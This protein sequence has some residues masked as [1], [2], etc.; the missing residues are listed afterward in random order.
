ME[1]PRIGI[2]GASGFVGRYLID[3]L[4]HQSYS[5]VA[6]SREKNPNLPQ[7]VKIINGDLGTGRGLASFLKN[8]DILVHLAGQVLPGTTTMEEGNVKTTRN[9]ILKAEK[10]PI[11]KIIFSSTVVV[12][13]SSR[14]KVFKE[15]DL[16]HPDTDYGLSKLHAEKV[17][18]DWGEKTGNT[19]T[20]FRFFSLYGPGNNK[21]AVYSLLRD[22]IGKGSVSIFGD[23]L[24]KRDLVCVEDA[25]KVLSMAI[26]KNINGV[27]NVGTGKN[28]SILDIVSL[29]EKISGKKCKIDFRKKDKN[30]VDEVI[31]SVDKLR[32]NLG[33][34]P[35]TDLESG[36]ES[37]YGYLLKNENQKSSSC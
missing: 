13:G 27:Y 31:Y 17:I 2:T 26:V 10:Y 32:I 35:E 29:I 15:S 11:R 8:T 16:C 14:S 25:A 34:L 1:K 33:W 19:Y 18:Q 5:L 3:K 28:H 37:C 24:Q 22:F 9:L 7:E 4:L 21:G 6:F 30:I 36:I 12:Y 23:G 20:I